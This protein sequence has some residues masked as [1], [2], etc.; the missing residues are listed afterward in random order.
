MM[1]LEMSWLIVLFGAEV[2]FAYQNR[3]NYE[4]EAE[5]INVSAKQKRLISLLVARSIVTNFCGW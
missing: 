2:A 4:Q 3:Q 5:G 1:W